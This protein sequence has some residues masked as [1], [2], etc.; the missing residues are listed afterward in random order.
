MERPQPSAPSASRGFISVK[1]ASV[2]K[3]WWG[4]TSG[5]ALC[6]SCNGRRKEHVGGAYGKGDSCGGANHPFFHQRY[7]MVAITII[8]AIQHSE[9]VFLSS[10]AG[11]AVF[12]ARAS[13]KLVV[14]SALRPQPPTIA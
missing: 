13:I 10:M 7:P 9:T 1:R 5:R 3:G 8:Q 12:Q 2:S 11:Y 6:V 4:G 14:S